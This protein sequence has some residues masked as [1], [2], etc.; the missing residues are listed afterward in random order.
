[1]S[2]S[3]QTDKPLD[4]ETEEEF[5]GNTGRLICKVKRPMWMTTGSVFFPSARTAVAG[6]GDTSYWEACNSAQ[7]RGLVTAVNE[8][9][10]TLVENDT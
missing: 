7:K 2:E 8:E 9:M 4:L 6:G 1:M 3:S 5:S 10:D